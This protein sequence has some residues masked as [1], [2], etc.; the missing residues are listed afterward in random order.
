MTYDS[1]RVQIASVH[2]AESPGPEHQV[3]QHIDFVGLAV[4]DVNEAG[5]RA[6]Q[7]QHVV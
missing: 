1:F 4:G 6:M 5:D 2:Q 7:V 3:V